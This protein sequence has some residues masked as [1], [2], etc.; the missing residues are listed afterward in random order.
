MQPVLGFGQVPIK[1]Q[2][3]GQ[4]GEVFLRGGSPGVVQGSEL[5]GARDHRHSK[6]LG[7]EKCALPV[8]G[9]RN[10]VAGW[11]NKLVWGGKTQSG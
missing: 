10:G 4:C 9:R 7:T 1:G 2:C 6:R 5:A 3:A 8:A 11:F